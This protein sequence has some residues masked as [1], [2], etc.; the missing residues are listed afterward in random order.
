MPRKGIPSCFLPKEGT[1]NDQKRG[2]SKK[3][4]P[5]R[6]RPEFF[7]HNA[8]GGPRQPGLEEKLKKNMLPRRHGHAKND[9]PPPRTAY[10]S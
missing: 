1:K 5:V 2:N 9:L 7:P 4:H 8:R 3:H 10:L 6:F